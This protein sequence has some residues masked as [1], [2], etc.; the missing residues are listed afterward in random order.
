MIALCRSIAIGRAAGLVLL[1]L[2][3][4]FPA[5]AQVQSWPTRPVRIVVPFSGRGHR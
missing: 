2:A 1:G 4:L 5:S 3:G